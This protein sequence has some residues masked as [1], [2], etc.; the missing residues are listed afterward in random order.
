MLVDCMVRIYRL[1]GGQFTRDGEFAR[2]LLV[3]VH[4]STA[5]A[6]DDGASG[7][8][9]AGRCDVLGNAQLEISEAK[10]NRGETP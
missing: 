9:R 10:R 1:V 5:H 3:G 6:H 7:V 8:R 4:Q 2:Y